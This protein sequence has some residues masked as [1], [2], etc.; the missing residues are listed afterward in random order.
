MI[1]DEIRAS[2]ELRDTTRLFEG[3]PNAPGSAFAISAYPSHGAVEKILEMLPLV[4]GLAPTRIARLLGCYDYKAYSR[5]VNGERRPSALMEARMIYLLILH[6]QGMHPA[7]IRSI[8]Y[9]T[10]EIRWRIGFDP[11]KKLI[12]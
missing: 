7:E 8:D 3:I 5:W 12:P 9:Y 10:G 1:R 6:I 2:E 4:L 11:N